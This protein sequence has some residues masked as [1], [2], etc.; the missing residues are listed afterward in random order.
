MQDDVDVAPWLT[1][2]AS[3]RLDHHSRFG[4][5]VSPRV[6]ALWRGGRW[7]SRVSGGTGFFGP[8]PITEETEAAGLSRVR[9]PEPLRAERGR[10]GSIDV[11]RTDGPFSYTLTVFGSR[12]T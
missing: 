5:F 7:Q 3:A 8:S 12:I 11:T 6:A 4:T 9:I 1:L 10:S 2:S